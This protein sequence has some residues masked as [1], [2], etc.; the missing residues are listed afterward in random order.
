MFLIIEG[1]D[2]CGKTTLIGNLRKHYFKSPRL[3]VHHSSSPPKVEHPNDWE[4]GHYDSLFNTFQGLVRDEEYTIIADRFHL[5]AVVYGVKYRNAD[6]KPVWALDEFWHDYF[7]DWD[8]PTATIVMTD[9]VKEI[10]SRDDGLGLEK[11]LN[12]LENTRQAFIS[13]FNMTSAINRLHIN[14]TDNGGFENT[15]PTVT[16]FLDKV[17]EHAK[18]Q[19]DQTEAD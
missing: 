17:K 11:D 9:Y 13:T 3:I 7:D 6:P 18:S 14:I 10:A 2:R 8:I 4:L 19:A 12:D 5:G 16:T 1:M 15:L